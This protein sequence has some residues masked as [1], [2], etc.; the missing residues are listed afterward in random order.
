MRLQSF[1]IAA[2]ITVFGGMG[3]A[4]LMTHPAAAVDCADAKSC[5]SQGA[6]VG[7]DTSSA[8]MGTII[9]NIVNTLLF[10]LGAIAVVMIIIGGIKYTT[11]NGDTGAVTSA[12]NTI[13]YAVIGVIVAIL[14]YAIVNF[15]I[16]RLT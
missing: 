9:K 16:T 6:T 2:F 7:G 8:D 13:M 15:V 5:L 11:S 14:A 3:V 12:K 10:V 1:L 4:S